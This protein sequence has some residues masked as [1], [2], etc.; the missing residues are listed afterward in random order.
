MAEIFANTGYWI[1]LQQKTIVTTEKG[2]AMT[3]ERPDGPTP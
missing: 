2:G 3:A 1:A